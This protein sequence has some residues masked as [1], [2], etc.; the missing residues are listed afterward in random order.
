MTC[1]LLK[2]SKGQIITNRTSNNMIYVFITFFQSFNPYTDFC[3]KTDYYS[4]CIYDNADNLS[5]YSTW[6]CRYDIKWMHLEVIKHQTDGLF[7]KTSPL[8]SGAW[9]QRPSTLRTESLWII[10]NCRWQWT[11]PE[12]RSLTN[13]YDLLLTKV[14]LWHQVKKE[15]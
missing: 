7:L 15:K 5:D 13:S 9:Q 12:R 4:S 6:I 14:K 2:Q 3:N 1:Q 11:S 8:K 10:N